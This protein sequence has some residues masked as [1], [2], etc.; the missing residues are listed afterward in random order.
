MSDDLDSALVV[1]AYPGQP[2]SDEL[3]RLA[4]EGLRPRKDYVEVARALRAE[5]IDYRYMRDRA[6]PLSRTVARVAGLPAG[7]VCEAFLRRGEFRYVCAWADRL[8]LPL[9]LLYKLARTRSNLTLF[10]AWLSRSK[11]AMFLERLKVHS[12]LRAIINYSSVQMEIAATRLGVPRGKLHL[13][14]QPVDDL[15]WRPDSRESEN[16]LFSV[17]WEA[18][19]YP[20]LMEAVKGLDVDVHVAVG[21]S[22]LSS[23]PA[24]TSTT[25]GNAMPGFE[26]SKRSFSYGTY[27]DWMRRVAR[28]G[29]PSNVTISQQ[30]SAELLRDLYGRAR[31]V[32]IP[33]LDVDV[34]CG[35]TTLTEAMAMGKA[36]IVTRT[37]GQVDVIKDGEH[38]IYVPPGDPAALRSAIE[39]L[40]A[41]PKE[42]ERMG[43]AGRELIQREH[44][45]DDY[46][47][48]VAEIVRAAS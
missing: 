37:R 1:T 18:R 17:G 30:L 15:F 47:A 2:D 28:E 12:H 45:L 23:S 27:E 42:A 21:Y 46:V 20:T 13:G 10:S 8:G 38:G 14:K 39:H 19:D 3:R 24:E 5:V 22:A 48:R 33:L 11:K 35:V 25:G 9:A 40:A 41:H 43:R 36:V 29:L 7:Q 6:R 34:D 31:F 44:R 32:V 26:Q 4:A 16:L